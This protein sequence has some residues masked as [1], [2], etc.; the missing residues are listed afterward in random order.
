VY[1]SGA[2]EYMVRPLNWEGTE[3]E[4]WGWHQ[5]CAELGIPECGLWEPE[6][7]EGLGVVTPR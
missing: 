6:G 1:Q 7:E 5:T 4:A 2:V 3:E